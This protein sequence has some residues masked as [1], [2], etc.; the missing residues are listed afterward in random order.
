MQGEMIVGVQPA[1]RQKNVM[2]LD[3]SPYLRSNKGGF[4]CERSRLRRFL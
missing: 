1:A 4:Y 3:I 2:E